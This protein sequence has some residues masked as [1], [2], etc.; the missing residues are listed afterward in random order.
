MIRLD[1]GRA[2][3]GAVWL[4]N[5]TVSARAALCGIGAG[6]CESDAVCGICGTDSVSASFS[7]ANTPEIPRERAFLTAKYSVSNTLR[8][9]ENCPEQDNET[10]KEIIAKGDSEKA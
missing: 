1:T 6:L 9:S 8:S 5:G 7:A 10:I 4:C 2:A 3:G